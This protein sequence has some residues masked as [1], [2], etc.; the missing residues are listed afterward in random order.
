MVEL[1]KID[2]NPI[3]D[4]KSFMEALELM[5]ENARMLFDDDGF[6]SHLIFL[7]HKDGHVTPAVF[8]ESCRDA[9]KALKVAQE[10]GIV[11]KEIELEQTVKEMVYNGLAAYIKEYQIV[12]FFEVTEGW[13]LVLNDS[14][15]TKENI[16]ERTHDYLEKLGYKHIHDVPTKKEVLLISARWKGKAFHVQWSI[17]RTTHGV[18]LEDQQQVDISEIKETVSKQSVLHAA[19]GKVVEAT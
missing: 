2:E 19:V 4:E 8:D 7:I 16:G 14:S 17:G 18:W 11:P 6:H 1:H 5:K 15:V 13:T 9:H 3:V 10:A 12:G